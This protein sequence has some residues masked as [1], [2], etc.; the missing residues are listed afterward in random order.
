MMAR[1]TVTLKLSAVFEWARQGA[2]W[3]CPD[4]WCSSTAAEPLVKRAFPWRREPSERF[5]GVVI[6]GLR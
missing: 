5:C 1:F 6:R 2:P 4:G 3:S